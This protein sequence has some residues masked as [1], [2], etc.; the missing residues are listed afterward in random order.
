MS[1]RS[2]VCGSHVTSTI[3]VTLTT[4]P[5][6][7]HNSEKKM[8]RTA[9]RVARPAAHA[10]RSALTP[11]SAARSLHSTVRVASGGPAAPSIY[12]PGGKP[13]EVPSDYEQATGLERLQLLGELEGVNVFDD[14]VLDSSRIGTKANPILVPSYVCLSYF[15]RVIS[16]QDSL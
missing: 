14:S 8:F 13:G 5:V 3:F 9:A 16:V 4:P 10:A 11:R 2:E 1:Y 7:F 12:G 6:S 15:C